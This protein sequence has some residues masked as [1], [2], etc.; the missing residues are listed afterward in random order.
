ME[1]ALITRVL[2]DT[3]VYIALLRDRA[4]ALDFRPWYEVGLARTYM[5][6]V[7]VQELLAGAWTARERRQA[8]E[9]Y[10]PFE[11]VRRV[12]TPTHELWKDAGTLIA[13]M[14]RHVPRLGSRVRGGLLSD[15]LVALTARSIGATV[16]T[17]N[18]RD[19]EL[20]NDFRPFRLHVV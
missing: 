3:S 6:S 16:V 19:F 9:L 20:I 13:L 2:V 15:L 18:R 14:S 8:S 1:G 4:F 10:E 5:S 12:V 7:V 17:R 11:R